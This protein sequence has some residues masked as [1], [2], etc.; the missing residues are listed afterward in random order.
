MNVEK[1]SRRYGNRFTN[2][3]SSWPC[4]HRRNPTRKRR[5]RRNPTKQVVVIKGKA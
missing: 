3:Y 4:G 1:H 5:G 2:P